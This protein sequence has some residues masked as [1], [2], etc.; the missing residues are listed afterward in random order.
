MRQPGHAHDHLPDVLAQHALLDDLDAGQQHRLLLH[1]GGGE[2]PAAEGHAAGVELVRAGAGPGDAPAFVEDRHHDRHVGLV[3]GA[4]I[5]IV[6]DEHVALVDPGIV[7]E[8][9]DDAVDHGRH[10]AGVE[11]H[12]RP[13]VHDRAVGEIDADVEVGRFRH[14]RRAGNVLQ[15]DR[16]FF[17][18]RLE[19]VADHLEGDR[20]DSVVRPY[21]VVRSTFIGLSE[22]SAARSMERLPAS[23]SSAVWPRPDIDR[24]FRMLDH[25]R[26]RRYEIRPAFRAIGRRRP[27][28][29]PASSARRCGAVPASAR[30]V[31]LG[32]RIDGLRVRPTATTR[33]VVSSMP[34]KRKPGALAVDGFVGFLEQF[35]QCPRRRGCQ[36][37][38]RHRHH[39]IVRLP[40]VAHVDAARQLA[41][42]R[43]RSPIAPSPLRQRCSN[44]AKTAFDGFEIEPIP[45]IARPAAAAQKQR[46]FG[47]LLD[48]GGQ[49][50]I[51]RMRHAGGRD[52]DAR[53]AEF[54]AIAGAMR[55]TGAAIGEQHEFA[56]IVA[57]ADRH[58]AQGVGHVAVDDA[59]D[60]GR[61]GF[62]AHAQR[63]G[64]LLADRRGRSGEIEL[65]AAAEEIVGSRSCRAPGRRR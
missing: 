13:H 14:H 19:L 28:S 2:G 6:E 16:L 29:R 17:G 37:T 40:A 53:N 11:D 24:G 12:L 23:S 15:R 7:A 27:R 36:R 33:K 38:V 1:V 50:A 3:D 25:R 56:R 64:D 57:A 20:I 4:A 60:A 59:A 48:I 22:P 46:P 52:E 35:D 8:M 18:D 44:S 62:D 32:L 39:E 5:G 30:R 54:A 41:T 58:F 34:A 65:H 21:S 51:G 45:R 9:L 26:A 10:G 55:R 47:G 63:L 61:G 42:D 43:A 31:A 49:R